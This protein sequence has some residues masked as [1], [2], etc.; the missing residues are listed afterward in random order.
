MRMPR[1]TRKGLFTASVCSGSFGAALA[2]TLLTSRAASAQL[3]DRFDPAERGSRFFVADSLELEAARPRV[4]AGVVV[5]YARELRTFEQARGDREASTLVSSS[6]WIRP[7]AS[8]AIA[9]GARLGLDVPIAVQ[10]GEAATL[11]GTFHGAP[12][13]PRLGDVRLAF[14]LRLFGGYRAS[15]DGALLAAGVVAYLPTGSRADFTGDDFTRIGARLSFAGKRGLFVGAARAGFLYRRDDIPGLAGV[16]LGSEANASVAAGLAFGP[17]TVGPELYG[18]TV[19]VDAFQRRSTPLEA[20]FGA[21]VAAGDFRAGVGVGTLVVSGLGASPLRA[22][23]SLEWAPASKPSDRDADGV[24]D[25]DDACPDV[26]GAA[27]GGAE[28]G[29]PP[30]PRD[31][32]G[33]GVVDEQDACPDL[34]GIRTRDPMTNGCPDADRDGVPDPLDACPAVAGDRSPLPRFDG[35]PADADGDGIADLNDAC[36]D[37]PGVAS[38]DL[39]KNGCAPPPPPPSDRDGDDIADV[40]DACPDV[41]GVPSPD[42]SANGCPMIRREGDVLALAQPITFDAAGKTLPSSE[43]VLAALAAYLVVDHPEI[44]RLRIDVRAPGKGRAARQGEAIASRLAAYGAPRKRLAV[45]V[46][47]A[48]DPKLELRVLPK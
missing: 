45:R 19:L 10:S 41:R 46:A 44:A 43:P 23:L 38:K 2:C 37:E 16:S 35:C 47:E 3:L 7:G 1:S 25:G 20:L 30:A 17:V 28:R 27:T 32:D 11:A 5:S 12:E 15:G 4:A 40:D 8:I 33:D 29:C 36:P 6:L 18:S 34:G 26:A 48:K 42:A 24:P 9:P 14:D 13:S 21:H 39:G 31:R 22:V